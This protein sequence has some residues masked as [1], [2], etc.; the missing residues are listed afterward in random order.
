MRKAIIFGVVGILFVGVVIAQLI[1]LPAPQSGDKIFKICPYELP[2]DISYDILNE[3]NNGLQI[4]REVQ[5]KIRM[6]KC[7]KGYKFNVTSNILSPSSGAIQTHIE[8]Y[9]LASALNIT[10]SNTPTISPVGNGGFTI[11]G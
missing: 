9:L 4:E 11:N 8:N 3:W 7:E 5:A 6:P 10:N 2:M 1:G